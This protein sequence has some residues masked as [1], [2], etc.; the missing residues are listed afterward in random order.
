MQIMAE[1]NDI[2]EDVEEVQEDTDVQEDI[3][4]DVQ[5]ESKVEKRIKQLSNKVKLTSKERDELAEAKEK[6]EVERDTAKKE[7]EF[8]SAFSDTT[9]KY[10]AAK[11]YKEDIKKK[12]M[13]GYSIEDAAV[14]ILAKEGKLTSANSTDSPAGGSATNTPM[15]GEPK[16]LSEMTLDEK[17]AA[18]E[19]AIEKGDIGLE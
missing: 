16:S 2:Q 17:R 13:S 9:D 12:V 1:E 19:K 11:E 6:L 10:P 15:T 7:V 4:E 5:Q 18:L 14:S 8:Y 3:Q